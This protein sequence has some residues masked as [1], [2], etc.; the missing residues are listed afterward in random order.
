MV[1]DLLSAK[2]EMFCRAY[3]A[4]ESDTYGKAGKSAV[5]AGYPE[6]TASN[7]AS[8]LRRKSNI[9]ERI[10][11]I[12]KENETGVGEVMSNL[13]Y[14][15]QLAEGKGDIATMARCDELMGKRYGL[16]TERIGL[17]VEDVGRKL[18]EAEAAEAAEIAKLRLERFAQSCLDDS[19][20]GEGNKR[21]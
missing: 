10:R 1:E 8:K 7:M 16:F 5:F 18:D 21:T 17:D 19:N 11:E 14:D 13:R 20:N 9:D 12:Y 15:R 4:P 2:E 3:A 6:K